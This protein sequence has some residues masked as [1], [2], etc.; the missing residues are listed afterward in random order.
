MILGAHV[1]T[2]GGFHEAVAR[3]LSDRAE[4]VQIFTKSSRMWR[5]KEITDAA[6]LE[7]REAHRA[8]GLGLTTV[9]ASYLINLASDD[10]ALRDRSIASLTDELRRC[11][12]LGSPYLVLHPGSHPD[13][14]RGL[15]NVSA[16][17]D[18]VFVQYQ[19]RATLLLE[20]MAG[21]GNCL[22][23]TFEELAELRN[24]CKSPHRV[25]FCFDTCHVFAAGYDISTGRGYDRTMRRFD[26][27]VGLDLLKAFHLNDSKK[28]LGC[29]VDRHEQVCKGC[30]GEGPFRSLVNDSTFRDV[31]GYLEIPPSGNR[32]CLR[33][34]RSFRPSPASSGAG[35]RSPGRKPGR[36][37]AP[38][39]AAD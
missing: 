12:Q 6:S 24:R 5:A 38:T 14:K 15:R 32:S 8:S 23:A 29:R 33:R 2:S 39:G 17:M 35:R 21:Q 7:Y 31:P 18:R 11:D 37:L 28:H 13:R 20:T 4:A 25:A 26:D 3:G 30:I 10:P 34:L 36:V 9:H 1:S 16:A 19:G 22:G 27:V